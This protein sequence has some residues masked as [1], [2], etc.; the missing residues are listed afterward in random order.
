MRY[1][2]YTIYQLLEATIGANTV[3]GFTSDMP[4][5]VFQGLDAVH[6]MKFDEKHN[7]YA[8]RGIR[9]VTGG[10]QLSESAMS[11]GPLHTLLKKH[12]E[13]HP[14][15]SGCP[16]QLIVMD[17][18]S[19]VDGYDGYR[20]VDNVIQVMSI[21]YYPVDESCPEYCLALFTE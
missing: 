5:Y 2:Y 11:A 16:I 21:A 15:G 14:L 8:L 9:C 13:K 3:N 18:N 12:C 6:S 20:L 1:S 7:I 17:E 10:H 4:V 19:S